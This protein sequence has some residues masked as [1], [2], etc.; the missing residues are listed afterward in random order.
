MP[1]YRLLGLVNR[2]DYHVQI[3]AAANNDFVEIILI[4]SCM[5]CEFYGVCSGEH[6]WNSC[7]GSSFLI[8]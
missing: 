8:L 1:V 5:I 7:V 2:G 6:E 3:E 4:G